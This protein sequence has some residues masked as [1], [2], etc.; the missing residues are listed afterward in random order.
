MKRSGLII[1]LEVSIIN[2]NLLDEGGYKL[3]NSEKEYN[4]DLV[5]E[6][7]SLNKQNNIINIRTESK[8][9]SGEHNLRVKPPENGLM[10]RNFSKPFKF[11]YSFDSEINKDNW[12]GQSE[13]GCREYKAFGISSGSAGTGTLTNTR[14]FEF[15]NRMYMLCESYN[16]HLGKYSR[17]ANLY[18]YDES[19]STFNLLY[20]FYN[21]I[22]DE[23]DFSSG[24]QEG[25]PDYIIHKGKLFIVFRIANY[26]E[27]I[28]QIIVNSPLNDDLT[29]WQETSRIDVE[30]TSSLNLFS[31]RL[32]ACSND[33]VMMIVYYGTAQRERASDSVLLETQDMRVFTSFDDGYN[34][35]TKNTN[36]QNIIIND[37]GDY[38]RPQTTL[39]M[40]YMFIPEFSAE[41]EPN[42][43]INFNTKFS[44]YYDKTMASFVIMKC[45]D[46]VFTGNRKYL[47][48]IK[49]VSGSFD[50]WEMCL[51]Y[52]L[53]IAANGD[54]LTQDFY[55]QYDPFDETL[56][57]E[58][59]NSYTVEEVEIVSGE[60]NNYLFMV[61]QNYLN[62]NGLGS[63]YKG[64]VFSEFRFVPDNI[65]QPGFYDKIFAYGGKFHPEYSFVSS[66]INKD[67][68]GLVCTGNNSKYT[69][70]GFTYS[71]ISATYYRGMIA[72]TCKTSLNTNKFICFMKNYS[73]VGERI[74]YQHSFTRYLQNITDFDWS[75]ISSLGANYYDLSNF[76]QRYTIS[77]VAGHSYHQLGHST[78]MTNSPNVIQ[79]ASMNN[80]PFFKIRFQ[81]RFFSLT[82]VN[83]V[84]FLSI[85]TANNVTGNGYS[86][87]LTVDGSGNVTAQSVL[88]TVYGVV[89]TIDLTKTYDFLVGVSYYRDNSIRYFFWYKALG[90]LEW[91]YGDIENATLH[92]VAT[93]QAR[94]GIISATSTTSSV[95]IG[96]IMISCY[97]A[98]CRPSF[99]EDKNSISS[100]SDGPLLYSFLSSNDLY[101]YHSGTVDTFSNQAKLHDGS[102]LKFSGKTEVNDSGS[103][104]NYARTFS[105]NSLKNIISEIADFGVD[106]TG[107]Y[108]QD[109]PLEIV[110]EN[111]NR[112]YFDSFSIINCTG[113]YEVILTLGIYDSGSSSWFSS[114]EIIYSIPYIVL[115]LESFYDK[116]I[117]VTNEDLIQD[118][119]KNFTISFYNLATNEIV[120]IVLVTQNY[121]KVIEIDKAIVSFDDIEIRLHYNIATFEI[122]PS[123]LT[124]SIQNMSITVSSINTAS[125]IYIGEVVFGFFKDISNFVNQ[126]NHSSTSENKTITSTENY[127]YYNLKTDANNI[128]IIEIGFNTLSSLRG[129]YIYIESL[130]KSLYNA[131][132]PIILL[133]S[134]SD[135]SRLSYYCSPGAKPDFSINGLY[136][137]VKIS[138]IA[139]NFYPKRI[140]RGF[141]S[142]PSLDLIVQNTEPYLGESVVFDLFSFDEDGDTLSYL[143][144]MQDGTTYNVKTFSHSFA[145]YGVFN[146]SCTV[147]DSYGNQN[148]KFISIFVNESNISYYFVA[149][150]GPVT[151]PLITVVT[152]TIIARDSSDT[153]LTNDNSTILFILGSAASPANFFIDLDMDGTFNELSA[154]DIVKRLQ[155]GQLQFNCYSTSAQ[156]VTIN[157]IDSSFRQG[158]FVLIFA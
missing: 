151:K 6:G 137:N 26:T 123:Y 83:T 21:A 28:N 149:A 141:N 58:N 99:S 120:D 92:N 52:R 148:Q 89:A 128:E 94:L 8:F 91:I 68:N 19:F 109:L 43:Y 30:N 119:L 124:S 122:D 98:A 1:P 16:Y 55:Y 84:K 53:D 103:Q 3:I 46:P 20:R 78:G 62:Q 153:N 71:D 57:S 152:V 50:T 47:M 44:L 69:S 45:G 38:V 79:R 65:I 111:V 158:S 66:V 67:Y 101:P 73:N 134:E 90:D 145:S 112:E 41:S 107:L 34:F 144:D 117:I 12:L 125:M 102:V 154:D 17:F 136:R 146:V 105:A 14:I 110:F 42:S 11:M 150:T 29:Q 130:I 147:T 22:I 100:Y 138:L 60:T 156:N 126:A 108:D 13:L 85:G 118:N 104:W 87:Q 93:P 140:Q 10:P 9:V 129:Q 70:S 33:A 106:L 27:G 61:V 157:Y 64:T 40:A 80:P 82:G 81:A 23:N 36:Y 4:V 131:R 59:H 25:S 49:T 37:T 155:Q 133:F 127:A 24:A 56:E 32:R 97:E 31:F 75:L 15:K 142:T 114:T 74:P 95:L 77:N 35:K 48:G 2:D 96:D 113:I 51:K 76:G 132:K 86:I 139:Q 121:D 7:L 135:D 88:G 5:N 115:E 18:K 39:N 116:R 143:W 72:A 54:A 63:S